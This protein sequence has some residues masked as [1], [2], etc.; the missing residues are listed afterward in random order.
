MVEVVVALTEGDKGG[1]EMVSGRV[2]VVK[3]LVT[4]P[5]G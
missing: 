2:S 3:R 5:V 4:K 1:N